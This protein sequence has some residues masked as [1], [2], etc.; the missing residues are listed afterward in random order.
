MGAEL[1]RMVRARRDELGLSRR[2]LAERSAVSYPYVS[3]IETGDREPSLRTLMKVAGALDLPV[4]ALASSLTPSGWTKGTT[5][6]LPMV[7]EA[8][9]MPPDDREIERV[10]AAVERRLQMLPPL[11]RLVVLADL[12]SRAAREAADGTRGGDE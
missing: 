5:S 4:E 3:Q 6:S 12:T 2:D 9:S 7:G 1:G 8:L 10:K 11:Q